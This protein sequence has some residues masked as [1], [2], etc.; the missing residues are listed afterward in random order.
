MNSH[1]IHEQLKRLKV[2]SVSVAFANQLWPIWQ[3]GVDELKSMKQKRLNS[4]IF[5][6]ISSFYG[7]TRMCKSFFCDKFL[8]EKDFWI[9]QLWYCFNVTAYAA[10]IWPFRFSSYVWSARTLE[11]NF[12]IISR[13]LQ[14]DRELKIFL[15][16]LLFNIKRSSLKFI[17]IEPE[18][19]IIGPIAYFVFGCLQHVVQKHVI[20]FILH[21]NLQ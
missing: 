12:S 6:L 15:F 20:N 1:W 9:N 13:A 21:I 7:S 19:R 10:S 5:P 3:N 11:K 16:K 14:I 17:P 8:T 4:Y 2:F 18:Q